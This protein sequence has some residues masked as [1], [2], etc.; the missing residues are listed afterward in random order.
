MDWDGRRTACRTM[1]GDTLS[2]KVVE[3]WARKF[4][5]L[6]VVALAA[7]TLTGCWSAPLDTELYVRNTNSG[8]EVLYCRTVHVN[9]VSLTRMGN[10]PD[11][12]WEGTVDWH[13]GPTAPFELAAIPTVIPIKVSRPLAPGERLSLTLQYIDLNG[14]FGAAG[15][16]IR[17]PKTDGGADTTWIGTDGSSHINPCSPTP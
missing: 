13:S 11:L 1:C 2:A 4:A 17:M 6:G 14:D 3:H 7:L 8:L 12:H 5:A 10:G 16:L 15:G 9:F